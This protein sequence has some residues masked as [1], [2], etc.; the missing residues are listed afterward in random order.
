MKLTASVRIAAN[1]H[2]GKFV[3]IGLNYVDHAREAGM[4]IPT[5]PV[6][7]MK[8]TSAICGLNDDLVLRPDS[9]K[10]D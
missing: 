8:A 1:A 2:V 5:E 6:V 3:C 7:F 10:A 4:A 9:K